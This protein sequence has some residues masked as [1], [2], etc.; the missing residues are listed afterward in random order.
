MLKVAARTMDVYS[1]EDGEIAKTLPV[2]M[3]QLKVSERNEIDELRDCQFAL[4]LKTADGSLRRRFPLN[5][6]D[7]QKLSRAYFDKVK[8]S[9]PELVVKTAELK[10]AD[11]TSSKV[12]YV[13]MTVLQPAREKISFP[14]TVYGLT[15]DGRDCFPLHDKTLTKT[16][17][18]R[19][20]YT[21]NDL[22]PEERFLYAR[23][24]EK[25]AST[26]KVEIPYNSPINLYTSPD[27]N[28]ES[29]SE[30]IKQRKA[31]CALYPEV[32]NQLFQAAGCRPERGEIETDDSFA[33]RQAKQASM[34]K[35]PIDTVIATLQNFD[36]LA[37]ITS[38][39]YLRGMLDPFAACF[40]RAD[41]TAGQ[42]NMNMMVDGV[43]LSLVAPEMLRDQFDS[44]FVNSWAENPVVTY[45]ALPDPVK[46]VIRQIAENA[47]R[48]DTSASKNHITEGKPEEP[49]SPVA[50]AAGEPT[51]QLNAAYVNG[52]LAM[53]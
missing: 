8:D 17:I 38:R 53:S 40:K 32:L 15:I 46:A 4:V 13:D 33:L 18:A 52:Q 39:H 35:L 3:H 7:M 9:L 25:R 42:N 28:L 43:D 19:F 45:R 5:T 2:E 37:G 27:V 16:A 29:L 11:P 44:D 20:P 6:E 22:A 10:F 50:L 49:R 1:D 26:L 21:I 36:K 41:F 14:E 48:G 23:N 24:I 34:R 31:A 30:A 12:A 47:M 51:D